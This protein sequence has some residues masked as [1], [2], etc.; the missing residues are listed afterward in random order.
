MTVN[1]YTKIFIGELIERA[2]DVQTRWMAAAKTLPTGEPIDPATPL[3]ER[4]LERDRG[5]LTPDHI[6]EALRLYK[7]DKEGGCAGFMGLS[8]EGRENT[9]ARMSGRKLFR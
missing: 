5:P 8:L 1:G 3:R 2:R 9:A 6:R 4:I 7:K